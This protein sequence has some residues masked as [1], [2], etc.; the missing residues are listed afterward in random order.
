M[1]PIA[2][3]AGGMLFGGDYN[4]EQWQE[5][6]WHEDMRLLRAADINQVTV[7]VFSWAALQPAEDEF[8]FGMLDRIVETVSA[9][10]MAIVMGTSTAAL[11][12][13]MS[14]RHPDVNRVDKY[15]RRMRHGERHNACINSLTYRH[16]AAELASRLARRYSER[17]NLVAWHVSNE[18]GGF[19][20]C[21]LCASRFREWL[22]RRYRDLPTLNRAWGT[23]FWGH[24]YGTWDE[25]FPPDEI[26]DLIDGKPV[27]SGAALDYRTFY[28]R[29]VLD[30]YLDEKR[31]I[32]RFDTDRPVT[33]NMMGTF[34]DYDYFEWSEHIDI[35][36]WDSYPGPDTTAA[37]T[38][39]RHDLMRSVGGQRPFMLMEQ[40]NWQPHNSLKRPGQLRQQSWQA[41]ARGANTVQFFQLRQSP[42]GCEKFH[43]A[44]IGVDGADRTRTYREVAELG[45][46]L[47]RVSNRIVG[48][49]P[50][51][52]DVAVIYDWPSRWGIEYSVGPTT[53]LD[54]VGEI[55]RWHGELHRRN[56]A[57]DLVRAAGPFVGYRAVIAPCLY[58][59]TDAA[60]AALRE[61]VRDGG[62]LLLTA[63][64]A[65]ADPRDRLFQ[66]EGPVP[67][68]DLAGVWVEETDALRPDSHVPLRFGGSRST[69]GG[70]ILCDILRADP[71]TRVL[72][73]YGGEYYAE[74][75]AV[76]FRD[77]GASGGVLYCGTF[78][79]VDAIRPIIDALL[80]GT[81]VKE[82]EIP[83]IEIS[84][85]VRPDGAV[86]VF[87]INTT[88]QP[89]VVR[90]DV[91]GTDLLTRRAV[92]GYVSLDRFGVA[93][94]EAPGRDGPTAVESRRDEI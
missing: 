94:I 29:C 65:M 60:V 83:G 80:D 84:R 85:R 55:E 47:K 64:S 34:P 26:G 9:A 82:C 17:R 52:G 71:G 58:M 37:Q 62:R 13:W 48:S 68:R 36:S 19:C 75:P 57:V 38:A 18:Y 50:K 87:I 78:P 42:A 86:L 30:A 4:P 77:V 8:D 72:A 49:A 33:T 56:I 14:L 88:A 59:L 93:V 43:G 45:A 81:G 74:T 46:E 1:N 51:R 27:L 28:G 24:A 21:D 91:S 76:T 32:R 73:T 5:E 67:F 90:F 89:R 10:G 16:H 54:Y 25:I 79:D 31:A 92:A 35:V 44:V 12:A 20:W 6:T 41:I 3:L 66:G 53:T 22:Q 11:P 61:Y 40:T 15:G 7:N 2:S 63:M 39:M 23:A 69:G 70:H